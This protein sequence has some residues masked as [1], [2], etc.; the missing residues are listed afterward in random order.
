MKYLKTL[1]SV[2]QNDVNALYNLGIYYIEGIIVEKNKK[3]IHFFFFFKIPNMR[4][5]VNY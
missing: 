3:P 4:L 2:Q 5:L 1:I